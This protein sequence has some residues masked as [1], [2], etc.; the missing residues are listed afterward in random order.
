MA[1]REVKEVGGYVRGG[2]VR[3]KVKVEEFYGK[4]SFTTFHII[5][6]LA[7]LAVRVITAQP[8]SKGPRGLQSFHR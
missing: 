3:L 2:R 6:I 8:G 7:L 5:I 1:G 4:L